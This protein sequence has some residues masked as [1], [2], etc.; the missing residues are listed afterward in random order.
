MVKLVEL[1]VGKV[2]LAESHGEK[3]QKKEKI[4]VGL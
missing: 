2:F 4:M 1:K 3:K